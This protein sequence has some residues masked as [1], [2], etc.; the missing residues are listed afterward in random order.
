MILSDKVRDV[1]VSKLEAL[2]P[3]L[4]VITDTAGCKVVANILTEA[5]LEDVL[6]EKVD[7][8]YNVII[9]RE[10]D[11]LM[12]RARLKDGRRHLALFLLTL[13]FIGL[14]CLVITLIIYTG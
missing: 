14:L 7:D 11:I 4:S 5:P 3:S 12:Y 13:S 10:L 2:N 9:E 6:A 8:L 1:L